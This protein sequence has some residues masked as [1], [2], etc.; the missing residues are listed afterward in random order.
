MFN[1]NCDTSTFRYI[2]CEAESWDMAGTLVFIKPVSFYPARDVLSDPVGTLLGTTNIST[3]VYGVTVAAP[4]Q[5]CRHMDQFAFTVSH[6]QI[7]LVREA[8]CFIQLGGAAT[9]AS[10]NYVLNG[11]QFR[12]TSINRPSITLGFMYWENEFLRDLSVNPESM[13]V[14]GYVQSQPIMDPANTFNYKALDV[15]ASLGMTLAELTNES[16]Q[17]ELERLDARRASFIGLRIV[18]GSYKWMTS[19]RTLGWNYWYPSMPRDPTAFDGAAV[20]ASGEYWG[21]GAY[22]CVASWTRQPMVRSEVHRPHGGRCLHVNEVAQ[23]QAR[24]A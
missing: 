11:M 2:S 14:F 5:W 10:Y 20:S 8:A 18:S 22:E 24:D 17:A 12:Y 19:G 3:T 1:V 16:D 21:G 6:D 23:R 7:L 9:I 13:T 15:C 4:L